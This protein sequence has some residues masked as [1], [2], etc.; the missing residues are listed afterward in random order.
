MPFLLVQLPGASVI[1]VIFSVFVF[2]QLATASV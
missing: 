1:T 2:P